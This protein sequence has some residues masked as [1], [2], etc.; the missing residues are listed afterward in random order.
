MLTADAGFEEQARATFGA[1]EQIALRVVTGALADDRE[2]ASISTGATVAVIDLDAARPDEMAA[3]ERLMARIGTR[4]PVVVVTQTFDAT[5]G[6]HA[7][8]DAGRGLPGEA[9][10][11][12]RTRAHL[13]ARRQGPGRPAEATEAQI[14][15]FLPAVGG[16]G[17]TTLAV[18]T[19]MMLLNSRPARQDRR[20]AWSISISSTAPA[21]TISISSRGSI[22]ARSSRGRTASTGNCSKSCCRITRPAWRWSRRRTGRPKCA[23]SIPTW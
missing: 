5:R 21:P 8:A 19:A 2:T 12:G 18:Q 17:V 7:D 15:T 23:P 22:S 6:A 9:G 1:S 10:L 11:A 3:L 16:A 20:P 4:P 13:R 14:Y